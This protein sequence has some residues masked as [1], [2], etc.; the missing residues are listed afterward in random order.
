MESPRDA[1][2]LKRRRS[3]RA[4]GCWWVVRGGRESSA[5]RLPCAG[6]RPGTRTAPT[7]IEDSCGFPLLPDSE[8]TRPDSRL[9]QGE[10]GRMDDSDQCW[11]CERGRQLREHLF[12]E[13]SAWI[14][15][16]RALREAVGE[17]SGKRSGSGHV[18]A[19]WKSRRGLAIRSGAQWRYPAT[20]LLTS[21]IRE[22]YWGF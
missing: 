2:H 18:A 17:A 13:C 3:E 1:R 10:V 12:K 22:R 20:R 16:I 9:P 8:R 5:S 6:T 14:C 21:D 4:V 7:G 11:W 15:E 19:R